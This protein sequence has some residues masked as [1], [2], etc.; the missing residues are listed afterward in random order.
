[1]L[2]RGKSPDLT[3]LEALPV[4]P[5]PNVVLMPGMLLPLNVFEPRYLALVDH[6]LER[7]PH[8]R[9]IGV[10]LMLP[11][12]DRGVMLEPRAPI[13]P[14][15]GLGRMIAHDRLPDGR[16]RIQLEGIGRV[17]VISELELLDGFRRL[18]VEVL[19]EPG[20][21]DM[22]AYAVL[23]AQVERMAQAFPEPDR[24]LVEAVLQI[25]DPRVVIY[26]LSGL[27]PNVEVLRGRAPRAIDGVAAQA[28]LQQTVL[29]LDDVE[30]RVDLLLGR[31]AVLM[32]HL[33]TAREGLN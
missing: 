22:H 19:E 24:Q 12:Q 9:F 11:G 7:P 13:E 17:R 33:G 29:C 23:E 30:E 6:V 10:P 18:R 3:S 21:R 4:F 5:L 32:D 31:L 20:P 27:V 25:S 14:I 16:R 1:M 15:F 2:D 26:A 28:R 8:E